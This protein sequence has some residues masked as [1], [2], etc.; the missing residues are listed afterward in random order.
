MNLS[1]CYEKLSEAVDEMCVNPQG[2][3]DRLRSSIR[4]TALPLEAFPEGLREQFSGIR[5]ALAGVRMAGHIEPWPDPI[6]KME[7]TEVKRLIRQVIA[8]R[9]GVAK[10]HYR[11]AFQR[12]DN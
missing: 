2:L 7:P 3:K 6:D 4:F 1:Y 9:G 5:S 12:S 10:E 11:R 8:L